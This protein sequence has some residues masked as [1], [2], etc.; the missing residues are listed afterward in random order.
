MIKWAL[1]FIV[2]RLILIGVFLLALKAVTQSSGSQ[3]ANPEGLLHALAELP[4]ALK[5]LGSAFR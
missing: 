5:V 3:Y 2:N 4:K 1:T